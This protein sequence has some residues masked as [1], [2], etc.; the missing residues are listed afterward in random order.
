LIRKNTTKW[1]FSTYRGQILQHLILHGK[2]DIAEK[3]TIDMDKFKQVKQGRDFLSDFHHNMAILLNEAGAEAKLIYYED[4]LRCNQSFCEDMLRDIGMN[5]TPEQIGEIRKPI[6][7]K[8]VHSKSICE[9]VENYDE[10][11]TK[12][13]DIEK[14]DF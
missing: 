5:I 11:V 2:V 9:Y 3:I 10:L 7:L 4:F 6:R 1:A 14:D 8:K 13:P 12:F